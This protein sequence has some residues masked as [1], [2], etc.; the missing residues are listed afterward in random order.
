MSVWAPS[1]SL[2]T[3]H[4]LDNISGQRGN[5][6]SW[7]ALT[8]LEIR[9]CWEVLR[10]EWQDHPIHLT[11][12]IV[13]FP[14]PSMTLRIT[15]WVLPSNLSASVLHKAV[16]GCCPCS[17]TSCTQRSRHIVHSWLLSTLDGCTNFNQTPQGPPE[18]F[19]ISFRLLDPITF[20]TWALTSPILSSSFTRRTAFTN[21]FTHAL[22]VYLSFCVDVAVVDHM[23]M[24]L[25]PCLYVFFSK[26]SSMWI[27]S[28]CVCVAA[29]I[30]IRLL[31]HYFDQCPCRSVRTSCAIVCKSPFFFCSAVW[32]WVRPVLS[33][34][35][36]WSPLRIA[37]ALRAFRCP[38]LHRSPPPFAQTDLLNF[39]V[40]RSVVFLP[41]RTPS[42]QLLHSFL[43]YE[44]EAPFELL[45]GLGS[46]PLR[47][48]CMSVVSPLEGC[49]RHVMHIHVNLCAHQ[50]DSILT[51]YYRRR[52]RP[53]HAPLGRTPLCSCSGRSCLTD[54][55]AFCTFAFWKCFC[56]LYIPFNVHASTLFCRS[57]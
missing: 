40:Y 24:V 56:R 19:R 12:K 9:I 28:T 6:L 41:C 23:T 57:L 25:Q 35:R 46:A 45:C 38:C 20:I 44:Q 18:V 34:L 50:K 15:V 47:K 13:M 17:C 52:T 29:Y 16:P 5:T 37:S 14:S 30:P 39:L 31:G 36:W 2:S 21:F 55:G 33:P 48:R 43:H 3:K 32:S 10:E 11:D 4:S 22:A 42:P 7:S 8:L 49:Q 54:P 1:V 27:T 51:S 53:V 26:S